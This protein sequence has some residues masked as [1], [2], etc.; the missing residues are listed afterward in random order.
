[1]VCA[2]VQ[3]LHP[4]EDKRLQCSDTMR[5]HPFFQSLDWEEVER[6]EATPPFVP[7]VSL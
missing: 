1:V 7:P 6:K 2:C 5:K 4:D 3:L